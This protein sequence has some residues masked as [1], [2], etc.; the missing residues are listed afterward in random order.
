MYLI[1]SKFYLITLVLPFLQEEKKL[2]VALL[3]S[4]FPEYIGDKQSEKTGMCFTLMYY[5]GQTGLI[6]LTVIGKT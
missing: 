4:K 5:L 1:F 6:K 3:S 2:P